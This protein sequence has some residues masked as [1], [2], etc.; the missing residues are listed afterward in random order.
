MRKSF[1]TR[2]THLFSKTLKSHKIGD[3]L[4]NSGAIT[5]EQLLEA[6][7]KQ[8]N[9]RKKLGDI[10]LEQKYV[11]F[12][13]LYKRLALQYLY[14]V[15]ALA[16]GFMFIFTVPD[17]ANAGYLG[18]EFKLAKASTSPLN[19]M[20]NYPMLFGTKEIKSEDI[21]A[22]KKWTSAIE[23]YD[24][25][26]K[27]VTK[28]TSQV[29]M[30]KHMVYKAKELSTEDKIT[31]VNDFINSV[32]YIEDKDNYNKNDYWATPIEF[33]SRG[34]DCEDFAIAKYV[35]LRALGFKA[36]QL[37]IAIV[38]DKIKNMPHAVLIVYTSGQSFI[39]DNQ[40][41]Q[42]QSTITVSRYEPIFSINSNAWWRHR[43]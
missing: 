30:W 40:N 42:V 28:D 27:T 14:R 7:T 39:L 33:L 38:K 3:L 9:T 2:K 18:N 23:R 24:D 20:Q 11:S 41:K 32:K 29:R 34:G 17:I 1:K 37:R 16:L 10:L 26:L 8:K 31:S 13:S 12:S 5:H 15:S 25:Q 21:T 6:L 35:S 36:D 43:A 22:F 19:G 4:V